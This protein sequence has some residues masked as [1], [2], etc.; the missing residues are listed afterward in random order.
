[1]LLGIL[2]SSFGISEAFDSSKWV[3]TGL[4]SGD[5]VPIYSAASS[6]I[7]YEANVLARGLRGISL[8]DVSKVDNF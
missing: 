2:Y 7:G 4:F 8:D 3:S 6:K 1:M 5:S